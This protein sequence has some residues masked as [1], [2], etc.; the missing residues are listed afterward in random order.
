MATSNQTTLN[1][2]RPVRPAA[3]AGGRRTLEGVGWA[4]L[5]VGIWSGW[6]VVTRYAVG[7]HGVLGPAD[8]VALRFGISG[9]LLAPVLLVRRRSLPRRAWTEAL[10]LVLGSGAPFAL[11]LSIGLRFAPAGHAAALTPGTM[12][13]FAAGFGAWLLGERPGR[14]RL[15]G[16]GLI[17]AGAAAIVGVQGG[18]AAL[19]G[20]LVF[21]ACAAAWGLATV[22]MRRAGLAALDATALTCVCSLAYVPFYL[23]ADVSRIA[24]APVGELAVQAVYQGVLASAVALLAFNRAVSLLGARAPGFTALVPVLATAAGV[25]VLGEVPGV[26][27]GAAVGAVAV[28]VLLAA[29]GGVRRAG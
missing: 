29:M 19:V 1:S 7:G 2:L 17:A 11:A 3:D 10:W 15:L 12:P 27:E 18:G 13:L 22:R 16:L 26:L 23:A 6:F 21:L 9:L 28:G 25:A 24:A 14:V 20:H 4:L 8:L 5:A